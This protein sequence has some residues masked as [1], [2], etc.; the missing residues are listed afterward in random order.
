MIR[1]EIWMGDD[2]ATHCRSWT[3][4]QREPTGKDLVTLVGM[5][6]VAKLALLNGRWGLMDSKDSKRSLRYD[7]V[8]YKKMVKKQRTPQ[9][10]EGKQSNG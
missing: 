4:E 9:G 10:K 7:E 5:I 1:V 2:G 3:E 6:E 8:D